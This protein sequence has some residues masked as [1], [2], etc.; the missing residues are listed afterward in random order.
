MPLFT[1]FLP[2]REP[3]ILDWYTSLVGVFSLTALAA[4]GALYLAWRT[5]GPVR[6]RSVAF[7]ASAWKAVLVLWVGATAATLW[8]RPEVFSQ[9]G[10]RPWSLAFFAVSVAGAWGALQFPTRGRELAAFLSSSAF[11]LGMVATALAGIYPFWLRSTVDPSSSLTAT[12]AAAGR[13]GLSVA[14][15]WWAAGMVLVTGYFTYLFRWMRGKL[16]SDAFA[17][18]PDEANRY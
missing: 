3:G 7:S 12:N 13:Y 11:L 5:D 17:P 16:G 9:L 15:W 18:S 8:V 2:G 10:S 4:H 14:F 1:N 6:E